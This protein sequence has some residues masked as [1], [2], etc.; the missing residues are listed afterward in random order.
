M[1]SAARVQARRVFEETLRTTL[2][3]YVPTTEGMLDAVW[4][5]PAGTRHVVA[6][7]K[8]YPDGHF[9]CFEVL[10]DALWPSLESE[11]GDPHGL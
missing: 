5:S 11:E 9:E 6:R 10:E 4:D 2:A 3:Q 7:Y 8:V 1:D